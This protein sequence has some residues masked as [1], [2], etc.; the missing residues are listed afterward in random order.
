MPPKACAAGV[1]PPKACAGGVMPPKL[2]SHKC[3]LEM[4]LS[5]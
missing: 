4:F 2:K 5:L 1:L 3:S